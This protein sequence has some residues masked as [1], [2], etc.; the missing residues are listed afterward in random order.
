MVLWCYRIAN[1]YGLQKETVE[2]AMRLMDTF[3]ATKKNGNLLTKDAFRFR[4]LA[5]TTALYVAFKTHENHNYSLTP[6]MMLERLSGD[7]LYVTAAHIQEME[8]ELF[9]A[10]DWRLYPPTAISFARNLLDMIPSSLIRDPTTV[11]EVTQVQIDLAIV[12]GRLLMM[13]KSSALAAAALLNALRSVL[14]H[15]HLAYFRYIFAKALEMDI[16]SFEDGLEELQEYL[17]ALVVGGRTF[18]EEELTNTVDQEEP[19][20]P[21][22]RESRRVPFRFRRL[23]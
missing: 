10:L 16:E 13:T 11:L 18:D 12:D 14:Q 8:L 22:L 19:S 4:R 23:L 20:V 5:C 6:P 15:N 21:Q 9:S 2:I 17:H 1:L 7:G 3:V